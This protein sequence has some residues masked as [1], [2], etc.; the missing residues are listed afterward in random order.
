MVWVSTFMSKIVTL[1]LVASTWYSRRT[2]VTMWDSQWLRIQSN[3][4]IGTSRYIYTIVT[5]ITNVKQGT[6]IGGV[7]RLHKILLIVK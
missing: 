5:I 3:T 4:P 1:M 7:Q 6:V 2:H